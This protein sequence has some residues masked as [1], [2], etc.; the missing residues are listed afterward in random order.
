MKKEG[1]YFDKEL[2]PLIYNPDLNWYDV[3]LDTKYGKVEVSLSCDEFERMEDFISELRKFCNRI[4]SV[5]AEAHLLIA[6]KMVPLKNESWLDENED[7]ITREMLMDAI[8]P[9]GATINL[10]KGGLA[11]M[12]FDD[13][14]FFE[15][16]SIVVWHSEDGSV[17]DPHLAG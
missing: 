5:M 10:S 3:L 13:G 12:F 16:H 1:K 17:S 11:E 8:V 14:G 7:P 6:E 2:G 9:Q 15:E 4:E